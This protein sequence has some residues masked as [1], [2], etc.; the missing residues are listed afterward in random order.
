MR[1]LFYFF[2]KKVYTHRSAGVAQLVEQLFRKQQVVRSIRITG[3]SFLP[4][5]VPPEN[6]KPH[7]DGKRGLIAASPQKSLLK[8]YTEPIDKSITI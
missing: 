2:S 4:C 7:C 3:S 8:V 1:D 5:A 6:T